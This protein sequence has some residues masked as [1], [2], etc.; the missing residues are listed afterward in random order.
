MSLI[1]GDVSQTVATATTN[2]T[3]GLSADFNMFLTLLTTQMQN[4][5]P[6]DPMDSSEYTQQLVQFSQVEQSIQQNTALQ[7]ILGRLASQDMVQASTYIG[8]EARFDSPIA[9]L[10][11]APA[12]WTYVAGAEPASVKIEVMDQS[13]TIVHTATLDP[14]TQGRYSWD[15][16]KDDGTQAAKGAYTLS[17]EALD[18]SG[19]TVPVAIN[20]VGIV[21]E[22]VTDGTNVVLNINGVRFALEGLV[23]VSNSSAA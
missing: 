9:G 4:Q 1:S 12:T 22:V 15:G 21:K 2:V 10:G 7:D 23:A 11:D 17:I 14:E 3:S 16:T 19:N 20:S 6:L 5:D 18:G 13:G 8:R